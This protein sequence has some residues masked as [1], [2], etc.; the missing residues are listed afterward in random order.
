MTRWHSTA[1]FYSTL[2]YSCWMNWCQHQP[3]SKM[4]RSGFADISAVSSCIVPDAT[5]AKW[6]HESQNEACQ[7][8]SHSQT[9]LQ[10]TADICIS[11][12]KNASTWPACYHEQK[13]IIMISYI[14]LCLHDWKLRALLSIYRYLKP[15]MLSIYRYLIKTVHGNFRAIELP[16]NI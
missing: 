3:S 1:A 14:Y 5:W 15:F 8:A 9:G 11:V 16:I 4:L 12:Y 13:S 2:V 7:T 10:L 6:A